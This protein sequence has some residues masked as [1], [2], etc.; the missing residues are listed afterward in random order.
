M[1]LG[2]AHRRLVES[3]LQAIGLHRGQP[4][5]LFALSNHDGLSNAELAQ[6][7]NVTPPTISN[8][9]RR[10]QKSGFVDKRRDRRDERTTR[11]YLTEQGRTATIEMAQV[12]ME[13]NDI[14]N[15]GLTPDEQQRLMSAL[16]LITRNIEDAI[17]RDGDG[18]G[19]RLG[20]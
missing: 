8:M 20:S 3:R 9:V 11:V 2:H 16:E 17:R 1:L 7:L 5:L 4:P 15:R 14:I 13:V 10:M 12:I 18:D 19:D 6:L